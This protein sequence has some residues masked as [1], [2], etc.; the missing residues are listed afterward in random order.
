[1]IGV[2]ETYEG[3]PIKIGINYV[4]SVP[5]CGDSGYGEGMRDTFYICLY[6]PL[7]FSYKLW[8]RG[9][10]LKKFPFFIRWPMV[11]WGIPV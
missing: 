5:L 6:L 2:Y 8:V 7:V 11:D 9:I 1:M 3:G 4:G 10:F